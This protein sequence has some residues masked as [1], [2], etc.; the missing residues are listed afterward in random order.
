MVSAQRAA[1]NLAR[2][3]SG[4][5]VGKLTPVEIEHGSG[6]PAGE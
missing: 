4:S 1:L 6:V 2:C 5:K 3:G